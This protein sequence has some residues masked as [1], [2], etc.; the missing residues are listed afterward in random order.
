MLNDRQYMRQPNARDFESGRKVLLG[1]IIANIIMYLMPSQELTASLALSIHGLKSG[2]IYQLVTAMFMHGSFSHIFFNMWAL[3][4]FG[5]IVAPILGGNRFM[6]LYLISGLTGNLLWLFANFNSPQPA[7]LLGASGA[8]FGVML[9]VA[10]LTP[11]VRFMMLFFPTPVKVTTLIIVYA[12]I[13]IFSELGR[14]GVNNI[15][16]LAHLG[17]F[18]GAYVYLKFIFG[19][20]IP[21]DPLRFISGGGQ[22]FNSNSAYSRNEYRRNPEPPPRNASEGPVSQRELDALLDKISRT[23]INS[24][25]PHE[26]ERLRRAREQMQNNARKQ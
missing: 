12:M 15:A 1:L 24:L 5:S 13:E 17:G 10:M 8:V 4:I 20:T 2:Q 7:F 11:Q 6:A 25:E 23:G 16:H 9:A 18:I 19:R 21:W 3:Y 14:L 22:K 26:M